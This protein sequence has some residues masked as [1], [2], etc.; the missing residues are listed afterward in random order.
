[1][2]LDV[3][4]HARPLYKHFSISD[5]VWKYLSYGPFERFEDFEHFLSSTVPTF[6]AF[7]MVIIDKER[8]EPTGFISYLRIF[9]AAGS[10]EVGNVC[11]SPT[12]QRTV[13]A[14]EAFYLL[15]QWTFLAGYRR[16]EWKCDSLN[17]RSVRSALRLG[18]SF[19]GGVSGST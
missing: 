13:V 5:R 2:P 15:A 7:F 18:F 3:A 6:P 9:P 11:L 14:T 8:S 19:E 16:Y 17:F 10:I 4:L 1:M 12:L